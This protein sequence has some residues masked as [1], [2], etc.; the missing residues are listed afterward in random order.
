MAPGTENVMNVSMFAKPIP[1]SIDGYL[2][3]PSMLVIGKMKQTIDL[4]LQ[5][6][7]VG[8][9]NFLRLFSRPFEEVV[10]CHAT[11]AVSNGSLL[12]YYC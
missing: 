11:I 4:E 8:R 7:I 5:M 1:V 9:M 2:Y 10:E 3:M 6:K 12:V